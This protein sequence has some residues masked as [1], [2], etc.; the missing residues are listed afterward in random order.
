MSTSNSLNSENP[1]T[2]SSSSGKADVLRLNGRKGFTPPPRI[3]VP[4]WADN[5]RK[6]AKEAGSTS[7]DWSTATV[8]VARGPM[9]AV[10]EPGVHVIT[11]MV[12]TQMLKTALL[13]NTFG[14]FAHLDPSPML[15]L[16]PKEDAAEQFSKE[17]IA[18]LIRVTP[19]LRELVGTSKM[20]NADE[21]LLFKSFPGGFLALA[22]AGSPDNLARRP[23]RVILADE[24][25]KYPI[26]REGDPISL[27]EERT[28]TFG[29]WLSIRACSP[30]VQDESRIEDS[31]KESDMR[32]A[33]VECPHCGHRQFL[34]FFRHV[35]WEKK[36]DAQG[37]VVSHNTKTA[38]VY[39]EC[40]GAGWSEGERLRALQTA[41]WHQTKPFE[42]CSERH[43][44]LESYEQAWRD[45]GQTGDPDAAVTAVWDWW[46]SDRHA[47]YRA[48]CPKCGTWGVDN[49]HAGFQASKLY[50]PWPKDRPHLVAKKWVDA[51]QD[52]TKKQTWWNTQAGLPYRAHSGKNLDLEALAKRGEV[53]PAQVPAG[54]ALLSAGVDTQ[55]DRL[56][57]EVVGWGRDEESWSIDYRVFEGDPNEPEVWA[58]LDAYLMSRFRRAD[59]REFVIDA[60]CVDTGGSNT[61]KAYEFTKARLG[62][63][64]FGI[65]GESAKNG[66]RSPVWPT[67]KPT[68]RTKSNYRPVIVGV[69]TAKDVIYRRLERETPGPGYMH[70]PADR[71]LNYYAQLTAERR[72]QK[73]IANRRFTVWELPNGKHNEALDCRV[74][75]YAALCA[76]FHKGLQLNRLADEV[77]A[78]FTA[79]P[80]IEPKP[81]ASAEGGEQDEVVEQPAAPPVVAVARG[82]MVKKVGASGG[83]GKSRAS[84]LA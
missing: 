62:R 63:N 44:P 12:S 81:A 43:L 38:R 84:R 8:E 6:L 67:K 23:V 53:W 9:L 37:N 10:T 61:Q 11:A 59:G 79:K 40:C 76:L 36:K 17:R 5:F 80:Y 73:T 26:T 35:E 27:A 28:A 13:E 52:E 50:S 39:C 33:S 60:V 2:R 14:Y 42:C 34:D 18:P 47:V 16:Q 20:R 78:T 51:Q 24:V 55:P 82:P 72:V 1:T 56:E 49:E 4:D 22:G 83:S 46:S 54:V 41:R 7:G 31:Y 68:R 21:T 30:T 57:V 32:R 77:G 25:D 58:T 64:I 15:L 48:K 74:Y 75:A 29:N 69:N 71:D 70:F 19:V 45:G 65:K 3:S 66:A